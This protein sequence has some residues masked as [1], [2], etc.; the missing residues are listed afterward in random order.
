MNAGP[1]APVGTMI[2]ASRAH[3]ENFAPLTRLTPSPTHSAVS[4]LLPR[5]VSA[6]S[7]PSGSFT[8]YPQGSRVRQPEALR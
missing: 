2:D 1:R 6:K 3:S 4:F 8:S 7:N 5:P